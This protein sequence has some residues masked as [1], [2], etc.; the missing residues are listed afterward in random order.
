M[1]SSPEPSV[2]RT[3]VALLAGL[4][5]VVL[6]AVAALGA[7]SVLKDRAEAGQ[8]IRGGLTDVSG[9][10]RPVLLP[11][12]QV[13]VTVSEPVE[14]VPEGASVDAPRAPWGGSFVGV[15]WETGY[16]GGFPTWA[17]VPLGMA[18]VQPHVHLV[19]GGHRYPVPGASGGDIVGRRKE[20]IHGE[21]KAWI[22]V[23]GEPKQPVI[24]IEYDGVTQRVDIATG[25]RESGRAAPLY[26]LDRQGAHFRTCPAPRISGLGGVLS[27]DAK[28]GVAT[29]LRLPYVSGLGWAKPG[30]EWAVINASVSLPSDGEW[31]AAAGSG[32]AADYDLEPVS[33]TF[34]LD[35]RAPRPTPE[36]KDAAFDATRGTGSV[37]FDV[38]V[39]GTGTLRIMQRARA[40]LDDVNG[41]RPPQSDASIILDRAMTLAP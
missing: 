4:A 18:P 21:G 30:R 41:A 10:S 13:D 35:G 7:W 29:P 14:S 19:V 8:V 28:C 39:N 5:V 3:R 17:T 15:S 24:E 6:A 37:V 1:S 25:R 11:L 32:P 34:T 38:P 20:T 27:V 40:E 36:L 26:S 23:D 9:R 16:M 22:A 33:T 31:R 2:R 12:G